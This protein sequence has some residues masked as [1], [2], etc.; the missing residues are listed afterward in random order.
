[1]PDYEYT[2]DEALAALKKRPV[3]NVGKAGGP[4]VAKGKTKGTRQDAASTLPIS[5]IMGAL[6]SL[7]DHSQERKTP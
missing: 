2:A 5:A 7:P 6:C 3:W 4:A 1:M